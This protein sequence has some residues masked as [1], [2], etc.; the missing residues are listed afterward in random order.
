M[1]EEPEGNR[2]LR[3]PKCRWKGKIKVDLREIKWGDID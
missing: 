3:R 2:I 1:V